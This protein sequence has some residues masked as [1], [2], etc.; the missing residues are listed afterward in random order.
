MRLL[1]ILKIAG[2]ALYR[3][4]RT[5]VVLSLMVISAV[6]ALVFI[7][8]LAMGTNDAMVRNSTG[9]FSGHIAGTGIIMTDF[10]SLQVPGVRQALLRRHLV[11]ILSHEGRIE[12]AD[13][14]GVDPEHEQQAT[15][16]PRKTIA[17]EYPV[18]GEKTIYVSHETA[19]RL[20]LDIGSFVEVARPDGRTVAIFAVA[21]IFRTG[22]SRLDHGL[23]FCQ[24][25]A[26]AGDWGEFS[27][28]VFIDDGASLD[29]IV[30]QLRKQMP[31]SRFMTW[32]EFM[33]DLKQLI[34]LN[35]FCMGIVI[36]L[37]FA[38]VAVG[39]SCAFLIF[40]LKNLREYG[41]MKAMGLHSYDTALLLLLQIGLLTISA[42]LVGTMAGYIL[43]GLFASSG[44]DISQFTSHNQY[45][46]VSG[47]LYPRLTSFA[48][49]APPLA[50][51]VFGLAAALWPVVYV[52]RKNPAEI[53][54]SM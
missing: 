2:L 52:V 40:T 47:V 25:D 6:A 19:E 13:L 35:N 39:I 42:A 43:V 23:A 34:D 7:S 10:A 46:S 18:A 30:S 16:F 22:L 11:V 32:P 12:P 36:L 31:A 17:G 50:A 41:V 51:V 29:A 9:L 21:G 14:V 33:P 38:I 48:L 4:W 8:A 54:R 24:A 3:S 20:N 53:L 1:F 37:V 45:F 44:I 27:A 15:A 26:I 28:A 5:T 49:L